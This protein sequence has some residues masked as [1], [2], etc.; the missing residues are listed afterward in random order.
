MWGR[1]HGSQ[2]EDST[3][4]RISGHAG[5][6]SASTL[7]PALPVEDSQVVEGGGHLG[8]WGG[9]REGAPSPGPALHSGPPLTAGCSGAQCLLPDLWGRIVEQVCGLFV[10]VLVSCGAARGRQLEPGPGPWAGLSMVASPRGPFWVSP[11]LPDL[12]Q[13]P[14]M[15]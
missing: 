15:P 14:C 8:G 3:F 13:G 4:S 11:P 9:S 7:T 6:G 10:L 1:A 5:W 2:A 12:A